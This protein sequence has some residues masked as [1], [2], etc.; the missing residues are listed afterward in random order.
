MKKLLFILGSFLLS[1]N[2]YAAMNVNKIDPPFW[3]AGMKN[4]ELQLM[5][6]GEGIGDASVSVNYPGVSLSS[7]VKLE[8]NNYLLVYLYLNKEVKPGK[9]PLTFTI[10]KKKLVKEYELVKAQLEHYLGVTITN[11]ALERSIAIY[12]EN[13]QVMREFV[14]VAAE[15]PQVIDAVSRHAVFKARQF[16]LKEKHTE[17]VKELIAEVK[18]MP[19]QPWTGKKVIVA[20]ILLEPNELLDIFNEFGLAIVD[21]DL[22]QESRQIRVDVLDGEEG[23]L[24][25]MAKA[26]QQMYGCSVATD[27]KK[28][29]GKMLMNKMAQ[30]GA[31]AVI[32]AQMKFCD[33]EEW[34][35]PVMYRE[36]E[37]RGVKNLMIEVD[38]E[39][40][41]FEQVKT[42]LQSFVEMM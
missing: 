32:I 21:D 33:P 6:Y 3:Y 38:Q 22:A 5:V 27:T 37:E 18:A 29:R 12:N 39:V 4:P 15:Y 36:F 24:Y 17:L 16:M 9:L 25:R 42:R 31:D 35:Y 23:P 30:T 1:L 2:T 7:T 8:S 41:S 26:W 40:T 10:G 11:A 14:K 20:G 34:D 19:V 13:R 28:G